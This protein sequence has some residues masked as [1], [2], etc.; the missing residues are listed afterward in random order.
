MASPQLSRTEAAAQRQLQYR[1]QTAR[2]TSRS[3][4]EQSGAPRLW[5]P[6]VRSACTVERAAAGSKN[7]E[8]AR[9]E[10]FASVTGQPYQMWDYYG[11]YREEVEVGAFEQT[12]AQTDLDVPL[13]LDHVS[14]RRL[15]R[16][17]NASSP[18]ELVELTDGETTG[19]QSIAPTM[20]LSDPDVAYIVPKLASGLIDEMSFRFVIEAGRWNDEFTQYTIQR[21]NIHRGDVSIVGYGASPHTAGSG[22][23]D[24]QDPADRQLALA[25]S[26]AGDN[27]YARLG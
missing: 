21:V 18:L 11:E 1:D 24:Q 7:P 12:L 6:A 17:G 16:S 3:A 27:R 20:Q 9:F 4:P 22:L 26:V 25:R 5:T 8:T 15:A 2:P 13:V 14:S 10:G 19:L 23:R